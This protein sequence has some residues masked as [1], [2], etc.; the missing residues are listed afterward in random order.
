LARCETGLA[1][2]LAAFVKNMPI[3][4]GVNRDKVLALSKKYLRL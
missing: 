3:E 4:E 1:E 2:S